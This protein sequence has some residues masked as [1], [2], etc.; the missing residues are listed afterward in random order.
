MP[1]DN[2]LPPDSRRFRA[3]LTALARS[4][5][6]LPVLAATS[7]TESFILFL[8]TEALL[9]PMVLGAREKAWLIAITA[10]LSSA[11][12]AAAGYVIGAFAFELIGQPVLAAYG[13]EDAFESFAGY[14]NEWGQWVILVAAITPIPFK[15]A[16]ILSGATGLNFIVFLVCS[17]LG[18]GVRFFIVV[19]VLRQLEPYALQLLERHFA[20]V[21]IGIVLLAL[22]FLAIVGFVL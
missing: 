13:H 16:T 12:G 21:T 6:A 18:R 20:R 11:A 17:L 1:P 8:P 7:F 14:Y 9:I 10:T 19:A 22:L 4:R 3:R 5:L 15:L 2:S